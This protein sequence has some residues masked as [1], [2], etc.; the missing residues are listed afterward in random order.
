MNPLD[1]IVYKGDKPVIVCL[2]NEFRNDDGIGPYIA[3][4][5]SNHRIKVINAEQSFENYVFDIVEY[6]PTD[7]IIVDGAF[8]GGEVGEIR[9]LDERSLCEVRMLSTHSLPITLLIDMIRNDLPCVNFVIVGIQ[10]L[11]T[12]F[13]QSID[14]RVKESAEIVITYFNNLVI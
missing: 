8:F 12:G 2:G 9:I 4:K 3:K 1:K 5:I 14:S 7:V 13:G 11:D 6:K 10:I